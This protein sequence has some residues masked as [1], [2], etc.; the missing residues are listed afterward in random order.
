MSKIW[1]CYIV[2]N[3]EQMIEMSLRSIIDHVDVVLLADGA[4]EDFPHED[5]LSTDRTFEI[6]KQVCAEKNRKLVTIFPKRAWRD[7]IEKRN[8]TYLKAVPDG[9]FIFGIDADEEALWPVGTDDQ[10]HDIMAR[11][12]LDGAKVHTIYY[13][14]RVRLITRGLQ[15]RFYRKTPGM[16]Y[17]YNHYSLFTADGNYLYRNGRFEEADILISEHGHERDKTRQGDKDSFVHHRIERAADREWWQCRQCTRIMM[18]LRDDT[19]IC[20]FC[21]SNKIVCPILDERFSN[22]NKRATLNG[23]IVDLPEMQKP[24]VREVV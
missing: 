7:E 12:D 1:A 11:Y 18:F 20:P 19:F 15:P 5:F 6:A 24:A 21:G 3:E 8:E 17:A 9:D 16:F 14:P 10:L 23:D 13:L 4:Y 2:Y 22:Q